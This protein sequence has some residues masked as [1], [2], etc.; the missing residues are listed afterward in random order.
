MSRYLRYM[1]PIVLMLT[2]CAAL[3]AERGLR[4]QS[5]LGEDASIPKYHALIV[6]INSYKHW[7][8]LRQAREDAET[9]AGILE[10]QYG[11]SDVQTLF[12]EEAT[13]S[14]I[15]RALRALT[16]KLTPDDALL[17]YF[18]GHGYYDKLLNKGYWVP[19]EARERDGTDPAIGDWFH[20]TN[21]KEYLDVMDARHVLVVSDSCFGG[22]LMRGGR[23]DLTKKENTYYRRAISQ[24]TRWCMASGDLETVP[25]QS[26]FAKK[27][28][29]AL[30]YPREP[31]FAA[32]DLSNWIKKEV[33][34]LAGTQPV[35][36]PMKSVG[37]SDVGEFVFLHESAMHTPNVAEPP[38]PPTIDPVTGT[39]VIESPV[40]GTVSLNGGNPYAIAAGRALKWNG[41]QVG[42]YT[43]RVTAQNGQ[44]WQDSVQ[45]HA[46]VSTTARAAGLEPPVITPVISRVPPPPAPAYFDFY[47]YPRG[48]TV[49]VDGRA[50]QSKKVQVTAGTPH[51]VRVEADGYENHFGSYSV[52]DGESKTVSIKLDKEETT[53]KKKTSVAP[54]W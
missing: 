13:K 16:K 49:Y 29:Q 37:G 52:V 21:L 41:L 44:S 10:S 33:A 23:V 43:V 11:F 50:M 1:L 9:V 40:A 24:P 48:A 28:S 31:V 6:G 27:F 46:N 47:V 32:S 45:V 8:N 3:A 34:T 25:D 14:S 5:V 4:V 15:V 38:P 12:D 22:S 39:L 2:T 51:A 17:I 19:T 18:A 42:T 20:N 30:Q 36:G 26:A 7:Q 35:F 53:K 54:M